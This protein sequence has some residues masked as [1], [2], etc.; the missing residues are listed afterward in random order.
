MAKKYIDILTDKDPS[1][2]KKCE[3][4]TLPLSKKE[5]KAIREMLRY[6]EDSRNPELAE[7]YNLTPSV[8]MAAP[9]V[10]I[11]KRFFVVV[12]DDHDA[13][14][15]VTMDRIVLINPVIV[16]QSEQMAYLVGG[17]GC[18]SVKNWHEG[19]VPRSARIR[20]RGIDYFTGEE[21]TI[22]A[23]GYKAIVIQ[24]E[25]DHLS[26]ILYY[27]RIN[28]ENPYAPVPGALEIE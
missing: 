15:N 2:R 14:G 3:A 23:K 22:R 13:E 12:V 19:Y 8:G 28:K 20:I 25:Y 7:K 9:Q 5:D 26:G 21:V 10:G 24:H 16:S 11:L 6:V 1:L 27:D 4:V 18:L 17:E